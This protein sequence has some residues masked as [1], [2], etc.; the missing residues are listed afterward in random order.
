MTYQSYE[1][2]RADDQRFE[3]HQ[4]RLAEEQDERSNGHD[5]DN[6]DVCRRCGLYDTG[7]LGECDP[8]EVMRTNQKALECYVVGEDEENPD[9]VF[10]VASDGVGRHYFDTLA[11]AL[12]DHD[13][14]GAD[15]PVHYVETADE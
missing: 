4:D 9:T 1:E 6:A 11:E 12:D 2:E 10:V 8:P 3:A 15:T 13:G 5:F 7:N 14:F